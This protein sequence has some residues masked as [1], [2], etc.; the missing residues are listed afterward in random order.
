QWFKIFFTDHYDWLRE[1]SIST[2][3][4]DQ[5]LSIE[6]EETCVKLFKKKL[7]KYHYDK[8]R[9]LA[10]RLGKI[11]FDKL[12]DEIKKW[13]KKCEIN[14]ADRELEKWEIVRSRS[15]ILKEKKSDNDVE[16]VKIIEN[17]ILK[18]T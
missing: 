17:Q 12:H 9:K 18:Y 4:I 10:K 13:H 8:P 15:L 6:K 5:G 11:F 2:H 14:G 7:K 3:S 16:I 1:K